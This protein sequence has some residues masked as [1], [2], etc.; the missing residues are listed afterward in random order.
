MYRISA[1]LFPDVS[2]CDEENRKFA[3]QEITRKT[4]I[5]KVAEGLR[6]R[7]AG[8]SEEW[9]E[10]YTWFLSDE[11]SRERI[12]AVLHAAFLQR[13]SGR[14][15]AGRAEKLYPDRGPCQRDTAGT[16]RLLRLCTF[17]S[18][19]TSACKAGRIQFSGSGSGIIA[20]QSLER[21]SRKADREGLKWT[22]MPDEKRKELIEESVEESVIDYGNTVLFSS[23]RNEYMIQRIRRLISRSVWALT[24]QMEKGDFVPSGYEMKFGSGKIDRIDTCEDEEHV[25]VKVTDYKTGM[26]R[27][28]HHRALPWAPDAASCVSERGARRGKREAS[29]KGDRPRGHLLL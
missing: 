15:G 16:V 12:E 28:R 24:R 11:K 25:Y 5:L 9:K 21:F 23:A 18:V 17:P 8:I 2:P 27:L 1:R 26:K 20:H 13:D 14:L 4:G 3:E 10:L 19:W 6:E 22:D 7:H 29:G